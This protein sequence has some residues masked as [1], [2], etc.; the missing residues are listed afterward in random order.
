MVSNLSRLH[1]DQECY[2]SLVPKL[3]PMQMIQRYAIAGSPGTINIDA[4]LKRSHIFGS[5]GQ[6]PSQFSDSAQLSLNCDGNIA[7][8]D[9]GNDRVQVFQPDG[10]LVRGISNFVFQSEAVGFVVGFD[11]NFYFSDSSI[12]IYDS[13]GRLLNELPN[14]LKRTGKTTIACARDG[15]FLITNSCANDLRRGRQLQLF[16]Y[17]GRCVANRNQVNPCY[18]PTASA[19]NFSNNTFAIAAEHINNYSIEIYKYNEA[20]N[21]IDK[22]G[23]I[24]LKDH[25]LEICSLSFD[26][27]GSLVVCNRQ[28][29]VQ[30]YSP[31]GV[32]KQALTHDDG[33][34]CIGCA[35]TVDSDG[36]I[37][38]F[39]DSKHQISVWR[40]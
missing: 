8:L 31:D 18:W 25:L 35:A 23:S 14:P 26:A 19:W 10:T 34:P 28:A 7:V 4:P 27:A 6:G 38:V 17:T 22:N 33:S 29:A 21:T 40:A 20:S 24:N 39:E 13:D 32:F 37:F 3:G 9:R 12:R 36:N 2:L 11:N 5:E 16:D 30:I 1:A 15:H